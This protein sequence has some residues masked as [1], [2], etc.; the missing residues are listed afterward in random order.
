MNQPCHDLIRFADG[1]LEPERAEVFRA[2]LRTCATCPAELVEALQM[3]ARLSELGSTADIVK[4]VPESPEPATAATPVP[5]PVPVL[6]DPR[7]W[8]HRLAARIGGV[9]AVAAAVAVVVGVKPGWLVEPDKP[10]NLFAG[11]EHR[12]Y[13]IRF[14]YPD[15]APYRPAR[16][17]MLGAESGSADR[18]SLTALGELERRRNR[19]GLA[20]GQAINGQKP[21][22]VAAELRGLEPTPE[23]RSDRAAIDIV[24]KGGDLASRNDGVESILAELESL[25]GRND[26]AGRAARW[27]YAIA[28]ARLALPLSAAQAFQAIADEHE[29]GWSDE[30]RKRA[31]QARG[32]DGRE[33]WKAALAAGDKLVADGSVAPPDLVGRFPGVMRAYLYRAVCS[34]S[35]RERVQSLEPMAAELDRLDDHPRLLDYVR[36]VENLDFH[37]RAPLAAAYAE[38]LRGTPVTATVRAQLTVPDPSGDVADLVMCAMFQLDAVPDH[39][40]AFRRMVKQAGDPWWEIMLA[41]QEAAADDQHGDWLGA[42]AQMRNAQKLCSPAV[43]YRCLHLALQLGLL[44]EKLHRVPEAA[45]VLQAGLRDA[46]SSGESSLSLSLL[47]RL[48]D[49]ERFN[50]SVATIRAYANEALLMSPEGGPHNAAAHM[51][52]VAA[53]V[54]DLDSRTA[55]RELDLALRAGESDMINAA[56]YI[57]DIGR[58]DPQP[59]DLARLQGWLGALRAGG[60]S[61]P[62]DRVVMDELEGR[63]LVVHDRAA[64]SSLLKRAIA[65]AQALPGDVNAEKARVA[66]YSALVFDAAH[67]GEPA[68]VMALLAQQLGLPPPGPC[69]VGMAAETDRA[70]M[71]V[72]G[73]DGQDQARYQPAR[74]PHD[75][76]PTV[77]PELARGLDGCGRV[78]VMAN[79]IQQGR[80]RVLPAAIPWSYTTSAHGHAVPQGDP[81]AAPRALI[82]ANVT[83]PDYL[84]LPALSPQLPEPTPRTVVLSG[85]AATP[86]RVLAEMAG[87]SEIQFHTH[88]LVDVGVSDASH[89]VLSPGSDAS[90]ALTAEAIRRTELRGHPLVVLAAC[91]SA[92]AA[93]YEHAS[94]SLPD[95]LLS[96]GARAVLAAGATIPDQEAAV[97]FA[98]VL[99][100][101]RAGADTA[102][103]LRDERMAALGSNPSSWAADVI[104]FE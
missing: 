61:T 97:F 28:L 45:A 38:V 93:P 12:P 47:L 5:V 2:H 24:L 42:E 102:V 74:R 82:V 86:A 29:P 59:D 73:K 35:S 57:A 9:V 23:V 65:G 66:A 75:A 63:L 101:V 92:Q 87:A 25:K 95:A 30:A 70:V 62:S 85:P 58:I 13:E 96:V 4:L 3:S 83:P 91:H 32:Q 55:R 7:P 51:L 76:M 39:L 80:P 94:W 84:Q 17:Q 26:P 90:Y 21:T 31:E 71:V 72:R 50:S 41:Q 44:Y 19:Y 52:L 16:E 34:A 20:I 40:D 46:R 88:A 15:V 8:K 33:N 53:A 49:V 36:R 99:D 11:L 77:A 78:R 1:E 18:L 6:P 54:R 104:L 56:N 43:N 79:P 10:T 27:N 37:R 98:R 68:E 69:T 81:P 67:H 64:G 103:A 60:T 14:A 22:D 89:L 48:A 100:R